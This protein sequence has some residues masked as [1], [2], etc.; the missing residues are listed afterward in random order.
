VPCRLLALKR[1]TLHP[2]LVRTAASLRSADYKSQAALTPATSR[3]HLAPRS[4]SQD[5]VLTENSRLSTIGLY[6]VAR[7]VGACCLACI[8]HQDVLQSIVPLTSD[9]TKSLCVYH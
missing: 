4:S 7:H 1:M 6:S 2:S 8:E 3:R 5:T 9:R